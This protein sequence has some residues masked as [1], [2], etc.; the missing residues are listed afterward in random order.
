VSLGHR[1]IAYLEV[2][3]RGDARGAPLSNLCLAC[4]GKS[5]EEVGE[6]ADP[7]LIVTA[8][9]AYDCRREA[10]RLIQD[11]DPPTVFVAGTGEITAHM[12]LAVADA[13]L[14][15]PGDVSVLA[16][17]EGEWEAAY[18]PPISVV[19]HDYEGVASALTRHL[20]ARIESWKDTSSVPPFPSEFVDRGSIGPPPQ[21]QARC[22]RPKGNATARTRRSTRQTAPRASWIA[23]HP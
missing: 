17:G 21:M 8:E 4:L 19:R 10:S 2:A 16:F 1:R 13:G 12:L 14:S 3:Q 5:L 6:H 15:V 22:R 23:G 18:R 11:A 20:I 7:R 9:R